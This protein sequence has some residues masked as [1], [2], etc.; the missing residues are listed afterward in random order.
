MQ[1]SGQLPVLQRAD[2]HMGDSFPEQFLGFILGA[3]HGPAAPREALNRKALGAAPGVQP[4]EQSLSGL[5]LTL[6][7]CDLWS[8]TGLAAATG[9]ACGRQPLAAALRL[10]LPVLVAAPRPHE[11]LEADNSLGHLMGLSSERSS[12]PRCVSSSSW[13]AALGIALGGQLL[14]RLTV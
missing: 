7:T 14:A 3:A 11:Q 5:L 6:M 4:W 12:K 10:Q 8:Y 1:H 13:L 2:Q 9:A